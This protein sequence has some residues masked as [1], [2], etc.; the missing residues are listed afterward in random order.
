MCIR[1]SVKIVGCRIRNGIVKK[2]GKVK[3]YRGG[4]GDEANVVYDGMLQFFLLMI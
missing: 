1:D 4:V 3:V 2:G